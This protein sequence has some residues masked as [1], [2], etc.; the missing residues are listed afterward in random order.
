MFIFLLH[1]FIRSVWSGW[2]DGSVGG[3][4]REGWSVSGNPH[5]SIT[6]IIINI[7]ILIIMIIM[8]ANRSGRMSGCLFNYKERWLPRLRLPEKREPRWWWWFWWG[9]WSSGWCAHGIP[10]ER[11]PIGIRSVG[12]CS[13]HHHH[14]HHHHCHFHFSKFFRI[15]HHGQSRPD[16]SWCKEKL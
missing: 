1:L 8:M 15:F 6:K 9:W 16:P 2:S 14:H 11:I 10:T 4:G 3:E 12:I 13:G 5:R 7:S